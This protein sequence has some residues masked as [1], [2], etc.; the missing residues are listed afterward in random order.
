MKLSLEENQVSNTGRIES[1]Y[2]SNLEISDHIDHLKVEGNRLTL[3]GYID[4]RTSLAKF[5]ELEFQIFDA[6]TKHGLVSYLNLSTMNNIIVQRQKDNTKSTADI[7][8]VPNPASKSV[9][10]ITNNFDL[11]DKEIKVSDL[12]GKL[13]HSQL[14]KSNEI[15]ISGF[16]EGV[17]LV[18]VKL[19]DKLISKK[20]IIIK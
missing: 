11:D 4:G 13:V 19:G 2:Q 1:Y 14:G 7:E 8:L 12:T 9:R 5:G 6:Q 17:Y 3:G 16:Q 15:D 20:L 10:L 18:S